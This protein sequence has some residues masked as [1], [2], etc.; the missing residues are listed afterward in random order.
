MKVSPKS[1]RRAHVRMPAHV[2]LLTA[3]FFVFFY[4]TR[5]SVPLPEAV[6]ATSGLEEGELRMS[7]AAAGEEGDDGGDDSGM[8]RWEKMQAERERIEMDAVIKATE[9]SD[10]VGE[11]GKV[12]VAREAG[13]G[14][15]KCLPYIFYDKP[16][17]TGSTAVTYALRSYIISRGGLHRRCSYE[18]CTPRAEAVC[19]G[20]G[21]FEHLIGHVK[22]REG[23]VECMKTRGYYALTSV[24]D[25]LERWRSAFA[26]NK[27][28]QGSHY[29][30]PW[31]EDFASF[32]QKYPD[33]TLFHYYDQLGSVCRKGKVEWQE[34]MRRIVARYDEVIDLYDDDEE[35]GGWMYHKV[36]KY[37]SEE[38]VSRKTREEVEGFDRS[39]L[40]PEQTLYDALRAK[41]GQSGDKD[42]V[43]C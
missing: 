34:R 40:V 36:K 16:I 26:F 8:S 10:G 29:G 31:E 39:R 20:T 15:E 23:L 32:M 1:A 4:L 33:C 30:I 13:A 43:P 28:M 5:S 25:P 3:L 35:K 19:N 38:N 42:R 7:R 14:N 18:A 22:G 37:I 21:R 2:L 41:R 27:M 24:R 17:K 9:L 12:G 6:S 11:D